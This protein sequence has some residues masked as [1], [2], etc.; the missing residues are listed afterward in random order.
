MP[1]TLGKPLT[2]REARRPRIRHSG[3]VTVLLPPLLTCAR[4]IER[5]VA[6][7]GWDQPV[8]LFALVPTAQLREAQPQLEHLSQEE[9][10]AFSAIEQE[11]LPAADS[12]ESLLAQIG[13]PPQV[14]GAAVALE[15]V[16]LPPDA[17]ADLP[18]DGSSVLAAVADHPQRQ[19]VRLLVA[20]LRDGSATCLLRQRSNDSDDKVAVGAD[21]APGLV[22]GLRDTLRD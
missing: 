7:S 16:V 1:K 18:T 14:H 10:D 9:P 19:D 5:Y 17:Q 8:R 4:D 13:W 21:I 15:R 2:H 20:V 11:E 3:V 6:G 22:E 12:I